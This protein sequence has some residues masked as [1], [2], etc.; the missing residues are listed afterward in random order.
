MSLPAGLNPFEKLSYFKTNK[1]KPA[2]L[3]KILLVLWLYHLYQAICE[4]SR[5]VLKGMGSGEGKTFA[6]V[7]PSPAAGGNLKHHQIFLV[8][9]SD[10]RDSLLRHHKERNGDS[11]CVLTLQGVRVE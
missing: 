11:G 7:F 5:K 2:I 8:L 3:C 1:A 6:K 10:P 9:R 4:A